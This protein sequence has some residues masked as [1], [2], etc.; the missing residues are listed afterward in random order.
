MSRRGSIFE[1]LVDRYYEGIDPEE[2]ID[3]TITD[4]E[5]RADEHRKGDW[6]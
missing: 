2:I 3:Q 1:A 6:A 4:L 5:A